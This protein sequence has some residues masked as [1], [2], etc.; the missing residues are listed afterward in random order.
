M[1]EF[2]ASLVYR[3]RLR[4]TRATQ[5][6]P[7]LKKKKK[8][9]NIEVMRFESYPSNLPCLRCYLRFISGNRKPVVSGY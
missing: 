1:S 5:R 3:V 4:T 6:N 7:V 8:K 9:E 2:E